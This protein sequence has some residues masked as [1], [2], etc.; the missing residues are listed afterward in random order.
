M[1]KILGLDLGTNSIGWAIRDTSVNGNQI[2]D[3]GVLTFEKGVAM[4]KDSE[5]PKVKKRTESRSKRRN[6]QAEKYRKWALLKCLIRNNMC[7]LT[8]DELRIWSIGEW[9]TVDG[10]KKNIGR[11]YPQSERFIQWLRFDFDGD[12]KP[13]FE[14]FGY[15]KHE[16]CYLFRMLAASEQ[17][18]HLRLFKENPHLL[19]RVFYQMVQRRGFKGRDEEESETMLKGSEKAG[20]AGRDAISDM[21]ARYKTLGAA[22]YHINKQGE[23]IRKRYNLRADFE[24]ELKEICRV[25]DIDSTFQHQLQKAIIWQRPLRSQKGLVGICT[26][27][28]NKPRCPVSHP[29]YEEFRTWVFINNLKIEIPGMDR[30]DKLEYIQSKIYPLFSKKAEDFKLSEIAKEL[31]KVGGK[32]TGNFKYGEKDANGKPK[33]DA[34]DT[35]VLTNKLMYRFNELL[36]RDWKEKYNWKEVLTN[37]EKSVPYSYEDIWHVLFTF[38]STDKLVEF[39]RIKLG[40]SDDASVK[41]SKISLQSGYATLS[42][43]AIKKILPYLQRGFLYSDAVYLA[44]L[45]R[46]FGTK[47]LAPEL[48]DHVAETFLNIKANHFNNR[49]VLGAVNGLIASHVNSDV[50]YAIEDNRP[51]DESEKKEVQEALQ[52]SFPSSIWNEL[53]GDQKEALIFKAENLFWEFL[54]K[55]IRSTKDV[56]FYRIPRLHDEVFEW[57]RDTYHIPED[58]KKYL[59]HPSEQESYPN[60]KEYRKYALNGRYVYVEVANCGSFER[61]YPEAHWEGVVTRRLG[62]PQPV[63]RG[64]KN[65]MALKTLHKL[66]FL[67]N[68]LLETGK[69]D[70]DTRVVIE[71]ARELNDAN[72]RKAIEIWQRIREKENEEFAK[73]IIGTAKPKYPNLDENDPSVINKFRLWFDQIENGQEILKQVKALKDDV[74]KLRLW[75]EQKGQCLYTGRMISITDLFDGNKFDFEHTIPASISYDNELKNLTIAD[76]TYNRQIKKNKL[77]TQCPNYEKEAAGYPPIKSNLTWMHEKVRH[78]EKQYLEYRNKTS[79]KKEVRD[80]IVQRRH[81]IKFELDYWRYKYESFTCTEYKSRWRNSQL[82]DTQ[83]ITKYALPYLKT[84]FKRTEVQKGEVTAIF[85]EIYQIAPRLEKKDRAKHSHH[86]KD[87]AVLTLIPPSAIRDQILLRYNLEKDKNINSTYHEPPIGWKDYSPSYIHV[88]DEEV[89][90]NNLT[91]NR[92]LT[93]SKKYVR[94]RGKIQYVK[95]EDNAG[96]WQYKVDQDGNRIPLVAQGDTI[97]GQLHIESTYGKIEKDGKFIMVKRNAISEFKSLKDCSS[98]VDEKVRQVVENALTERI[99]N[100]LTFEQAKMQPIP[101]PSKKAV[102]KK[103]RCKVAAGRGYL[104]PERAISLKK[105]TFLSKQ[106]HKQFIYTQNSDN[107]LCLYYEG[108]VKERVERAFRILGIFD[109]ASLDLNSKHDLLKEPYFQTVE[110]GRGANKALLQFCWILE[111]GTKCIFYKEHIT[112]LKDLSPKEC[113]KRVYRIY[114]FNEIGSGNSSTKYLYLQNHIEARRDDELG[115]GDVSFDPENYQARLRLSA[116]QFTAAIEGKHFKVL[117]DGKIEWLF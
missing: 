76:V 46:L 38:D 16:N 88:I 4:N 47:S 113:L 101:F 11:K 65:P 86:A 104:S 5:E 70:E 24:A 116:V 78:L 84:I 41:F 8:E 107:V 19:G 42:L 6:Y 15:S 40:L 13:D 58:N 25:H 98:I 89:L 82:R 23:R 31:E 53:S 80:Q 2:V 105:H 51:L 115:E 50:R 54:K 75:G 27:E 48:V 92:T 9:Q 30:K 68:Y 43:S 59:W 79:D 87:A 63:S 55:P 45:P 72:R 62:D 64:F 26:F 108:L 83:I 14:R 35:K 91:E 71:I 60:A 32:I 112:E 66:K 56:L 117:P 77:P 33:K 34:P 29:L 111:K 100:G 93:Q 81:L 1:E 110:V 103:V 12:G 69:I 37:S 17:P 52:D 10:K 114:K 95:F 85:R 28:R 21:I 36:G 39:A 97:R 67:V 3:K 106:E 90:V 102:I 44:N 94:T 18:E 22:L 96:K 20:T 7:P 99:N 49:I 109:L 74:D 61:K 57:L 73:A